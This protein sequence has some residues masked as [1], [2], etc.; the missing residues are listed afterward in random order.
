MSDQT[1]VTVSKEGIR[2]A[3]QRVEVIAIIATLVLS[4]LIGYVLWDHKGQAQAT[5]VR[6]EATLERA[7]E[8]ISTTT[9]DMT[10]AQREMNCVIAYRREQN[11]TPEQLLDFCKRFAR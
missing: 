5:Q 7:F 10:R 4:V 9:E 6:L 1:E 8:K 11:Q 3:G 2:I